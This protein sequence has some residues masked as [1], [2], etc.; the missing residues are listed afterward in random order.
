[1]TEIGPDTMIALQ[2]AVN[3]GGWIA[4]AGDR[5]P[6]HARDRISRARFLGHDAPFPQGPYVLAHLLDCPIYALTCLR[7]GAE[8]RLY[9]ERLAERVDL[10]PRRKDAR[11]AELVARYAAGLEAFCMRDP[12]QWYNFY[13]F[14][15]EG[16][17]P[18][19]ATT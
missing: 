9:F 6:V 8:H 7:E 13:D 17:L 12:Y 1:V 2:D 18:A 16:P 19:N 15:A 10:P 11:L 14:W 3:C 5:T 4:I